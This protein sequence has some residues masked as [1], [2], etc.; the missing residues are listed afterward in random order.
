LSILPRFPGKF[1][2]TFTGCAT[3]AVAVS[4]VIAAVNT[5]ALILIV[6]ILK[7]YAPNPNNG[8]PERAHGAEPHGYE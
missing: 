6:R 3:V 2:G 1:T 5:A 8:E 4:M 7:S